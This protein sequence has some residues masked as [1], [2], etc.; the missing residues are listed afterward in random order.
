[1]NPEAELARRA[2]RSFLT[3]AIA[4]AV[5]FAGVKWLSS[6][7][8]EQDRPAGLRRALE[9]NEKVA[10]TYFKNT[11]LSTE[12][13]KSAARAPKSNGDD[14]MGDDLDASAWSLILDGQAIP[15][16]DIQRL[17]RVEQDTEL[18]S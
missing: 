2:R 11:H 17:R 7:P 5:G 3:G 8:I 16:E 9:N 13:P 15:I 18:P 10:Q 4:T 6:G 12:Y 14:G 1:M